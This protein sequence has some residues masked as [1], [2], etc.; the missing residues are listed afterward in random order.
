[1][2]VAEP[3]VQASLVGE[4]IDRGPV[5]VFVSD[6]EMGFVAVN[7]FACEVLGYTREELLE[8]RVTDVARGPETPLDCERMVAERSRSGSTTLSRKDGSEV[9]VAYHSRET[10]IAGMTFYV[11]VALPVEAPTLA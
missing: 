3:L 9:D 2:S 6:D 1:M 10:T 5:A 8:L 7:A 11:A 4:A